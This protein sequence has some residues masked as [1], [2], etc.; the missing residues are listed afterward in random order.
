MFCL[1]E[2]G[3]QEL[4]LLER[5]GLLPKDKDADRH[6][7]ARLISVLLRDLYRRGK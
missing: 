7:V 4:D 3:D 5:V 6:E 1:L 2:Y